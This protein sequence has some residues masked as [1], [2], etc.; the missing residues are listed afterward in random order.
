MDNARTMRSPKGVG[1]FSEEAKRLLNGHAVL[2]DELIES[3]TGHVFEDYDQGPVFDQNIVNCDDVRMLQRRRC[4]GFLDEPTL[5][6]VAARPI[7]A[8]HL[9]RYEAM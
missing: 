7:R 6:I 9:Q 8:Q 1:D 2:G 4:T 5:L 3:S